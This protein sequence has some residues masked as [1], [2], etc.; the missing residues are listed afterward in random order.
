[1]I[2]PWVITVEFVIV[3]EPTRDFL[4]RGTEIMSVRNVR[5]FRRRR[6]NIMNKWLRFLGF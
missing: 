2:L 4:P 5:G 3:S 6:E 1:M